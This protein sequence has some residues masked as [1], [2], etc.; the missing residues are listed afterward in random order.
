[1]K[2]AVIALAAIAAAVVPAFVATVWL[3]GCC[4]LPFHNVVHRLMPLCQMAMTQG[5]SDH[6]DRTTTT[7]PPKPAGPQ[8]IAPELTERFPFP[9]A[10]LTSTVVSSTPAGYRSYITLGAI[11]CDSDVGLNTLLTTYRI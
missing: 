8:R 3:F 11:R 4:V 7:P 5:S 2:R 1:M 10:S 6:S 9:M